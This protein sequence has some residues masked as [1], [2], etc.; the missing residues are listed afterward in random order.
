MRRSAKAQKPFALGQFQRRVR[1]LLVNL[2]SEIRSR[3]TVLRR[4]KEEESKLSAL[5]GR[6]VER[7]AL[8]G[9]SP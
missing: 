4:L 9:C 1:D 8:R 6:A 2:R 5:T 3:Q 7:W